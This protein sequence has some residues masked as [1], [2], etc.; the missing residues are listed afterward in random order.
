MILTSWSARL[1]PPHTSADFLTT[2]DAAGQAAG[3]T[4]APAAWFGVRA[5]PDFVMGQNI[6]ERAAK[7]GD[8][9]VTLAYAVGAGFST[10]TG[11]PARLWLQSDGGTVSH[12]RIWTPVLDF[13]ILSPNTP[14]KEAAQ[15]DRWIDSVAAAFRS[16]DAASPLVEAERH[17][18]QLTP[19]QVLQWA[20]A[21]IQQSKLVNP[22]LEALRIIPLAHR[23]E[24]KGTVAGD[25]WVVRYASGGTDS[26]HMTVVNI[27]DATGEVKVG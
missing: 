1:L 5:H 21:H 20:E 2:L 16:G 14:T 27:E 12:L 8:D 24:T 19:D 6:F 22:R 11:F 3:L 9:R 10:T 23:N 26:P 18:T 17:Q 15:L 25:Y 4:R 7:Q 13:P